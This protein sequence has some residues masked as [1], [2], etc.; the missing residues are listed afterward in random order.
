LDKVLKAGTEYTLEATRAYIIKAI[1]TD[2]TALKP[3]YIDKK[4]VGEFVDNLCSF[5]RV[6]A[7]QMPMLELGDYFLVAPPDHTIK[8]DGSTDKHL[9]IKGDLLALDPG[10]AL[11]A[12]Y[13]GRFKVQHNKYISCFQGG[14]VSTGLNWAA[15]AEVTLL[16]LT[17][18]TVEEYLFAHRLGVEETTAGSPAT[19]VGDVGIIVELDDVRLDILKSTEGKFGIDELA[20]R[21]PLSDALSL[22]I[23]SLETHPIR[24]PGDHTLKVYAH[25]ISGGTL[26]GTTAATFQ[27]NYVALYTK[28]V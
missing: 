3:L 26:Y 24:V 9:R 11:P 5:P 10:E 2:D 23:F 12:E 17:P 18:K 20:M 8:F 21:L 4:P 28:F 6:A 15:D 7:M 25:N 27:L 13:T 14:T 16:T 19:T 1:S 22:D